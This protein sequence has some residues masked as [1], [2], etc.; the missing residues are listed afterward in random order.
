MDLLSGGF[1][2]LSIVIVI[3]FLRV[4]NDRS[5]GGLKEQTVVVW[6]GR[7]GLNLNRPL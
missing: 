6:L 7:I 2:L 5:I 4:L 1:E 3:E